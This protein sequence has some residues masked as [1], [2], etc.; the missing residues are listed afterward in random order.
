MPHSPISRR[1][2]TGPAALCFQHQRVRLAPNGRTALG[3]PGVIAC[4]LP[5]PGMPDEGGERVAGP[6]ET[7]ASETGRK[8]Q[9][10]MNRRLSILVALVAIFAL[11]GSASAAPSGSK[12]PT[13]PGSAAAA[14]SICPDASS[15][16]FGPNVCVFNQNMP[17]AAI[18]ADVDRI[19][20]LQVPQTAQFSTNRYAIFF[21]PGT[22][23]STTNPLVFQVGFYTQVAGLGLMPQDTVVNGMIEVF[24][25]D[26]ATRTRAGVTSYWCNSTTN[27]WRSLSNLQLN[28]TSQSW[29]VEPVFTPAILGPG[30]PWCANSE[31]AWSV[32]Q[33]APLRRLLVNG[34]IVSV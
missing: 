29:A 32:S 11:A 22:Y 21:E 23:G 12:A 18:Q 14:V 3:G 7:T 4:T 30:G 24:A 1:A 25:N 16:L 17:Q 28:V 27:F 10:R 20:T 31:E 2:T 34:S 33:A 13:Q 9:L 6:G 26:C 5:L 8:T 19:A 15:S